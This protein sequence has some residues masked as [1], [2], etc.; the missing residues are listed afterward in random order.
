VRSCPRSKAAPPV[1]VDLVPGCW[2]RVF[3][4]GRWATSQLLWRDIGGSAW[5]VADVDTG[6]TW[7]LAHSALERLHADGLL[8]ELAPRSLVQAAARVLEQE[9]GVTTH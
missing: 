5:L 7:A 4:D 9:L 1:A 6:A 3:L 8:S 2:V